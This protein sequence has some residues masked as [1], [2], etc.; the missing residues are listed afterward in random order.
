MFTAHVNVKVDQLEAAVAAFGDVKLG[1]TLLHGVRAS[2]LYMVNNVV[3]D[4]L[5]GQ[6]LHRRTGTLIRSITASR[7]D[8]MTPTVVR[9][10]LG[11]HLDYGR[12]HELGFRGRVQVRAHTRELV[13]RTINTRTGMLSKKSA[14]ALKAAKREGRATVAQ[15]RPHTRTVNI[16]A[17]HYLRDTVMAATGRTRMFLAA[18]L[19]HLARTGKVPSV[20]TIRAKFGGA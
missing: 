19:I 4:R 2:V 14:R 5:R 11:T 13:R 18:G 7:G 3:K 8:A 1:R 12:A 17:R 10:W 20:A 16:P 15:V 6:Y 9:G